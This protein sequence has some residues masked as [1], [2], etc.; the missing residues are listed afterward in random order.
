MNFGGM[1]FPPIVG[2]LHLPLH[3]PGRGE[4]TPLVQE[5][6]SPL[7]VLE[8]SMPHAEVLPLLKPKISGNIRSVMLLLELEH[9]AA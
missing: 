4:Q 3:Q 1:T 2:I 9:G 7:T 6:H 8:I 5:D